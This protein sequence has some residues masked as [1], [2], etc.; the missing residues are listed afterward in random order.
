MPGRWPG[1][2]TLS[3]VNRKPVAWLYLCRA[4]ER[5]LGSGPCTGK[6]KEV[7]A[8]GLTWRDLVSCCVMTVIVIGYVAYLQGTSL[9][10][11][12][13]TWAASAVVLLLGIGCAVIAGGDL[14]TRPQPGLGAVFRRVATGLGTIAVIAGL[15][16]LITGSAHALEILVVVTIAWLA[17]AIFWHV[18]TIGSED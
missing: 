18:L 11:I 9:L 6:S 4:A 17:T 10:L 1:V 15:T 13:S 12:S 7:L 5:R 3:R 16:G 8:M 14:Y 2:T